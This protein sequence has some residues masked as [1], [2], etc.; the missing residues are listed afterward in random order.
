MIGRRLAAARRLGAWG[1]AREASHRLLTRLPV[2]SWPGG[3]APPVYAL[4]WWLTEACNLDCSMCWVDDRPRATMAVAHW[5]KLADEVR[6]C[7]PR[8]T[9]TGG[10]PTLYPG[11]LELAEGV[12][13]RGLYLSL[14]TNG[15]RL[16]QGDLA[17][18]LVAVGLDDISLSLDG[19][20][21]RH[22]T[23][24]G[25]AQAWQ[26]TVAG[27]RALVAERG[28]RAAPVI[29][30]TTVVSPENA[31]DLVPLHRTLAELGV[32]CHT[33]QHRWFVAPA[34]LEAHAGEAGRRLGLDAR[35]LEGLVWD[36]PAPIPGLDQ[37][38]REMR[39]L[40]LPLRLVQSPPLSPLEMERYYASPVDP[41]RSRCASRW[42]RMTILSDGQATPCLGLMLGSVREQPFGQLWNGPAMRRFRKDLAAG[43]LLPGCARCCGLFSDGD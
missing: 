18:R 41:V 31:Q 43:G 8:I 38:L 21:E 19:M 6:W 34:S 5:L 4:S 23:I 39:G 42:Y 15:L 16:T 33:V 26:S 7:R 12:K 28:R 32:D 24:R 11:M 22:D 14:N 1:L 37:R 27:I 17:R 36:S 40:G 10:E 13:A 9:F 2:T 3:W 29:R 20:A 30:V 25:R 35:C